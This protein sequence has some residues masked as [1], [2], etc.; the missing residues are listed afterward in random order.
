M[1]HIPEIQTCNSMAEVRQHIDALDERIVALVAE[2]SAYVAQAARLK[3]HASQVADPARVEFIVE[4]VC[5]QAAALGA[6][7]AVVEAAY[8]AMIGAS[9]AFE[10]RE[11]AR[12]REG[13]PS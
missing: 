4:R 3:Q 10:Q 6:P 5:R 8:R 1:A 7:E 9:I 13:A 12:L 11:F 2:R